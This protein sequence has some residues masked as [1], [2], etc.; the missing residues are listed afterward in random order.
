MQRS[1]PALDAQ[2]QH[3]EHTLGQ[4]PEMFGRAPSEEAYE[5]AEIFAR[6]GSRRILE[7]GAGQ[8]RDT[9]LLAEKGFAVV[10]LDYAE[11]GLGSIRQK[12]QALGL[13]RS[14][15]VLRHDVRDPLPFRDESFD[16]CY[17]HM[18]YCMVLK[19]AG[20]GVAFR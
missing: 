20:A 1:Q 10:A 15:N 17:S 4:K 18:L 8:G 5:A 11:S 3:W 6:E 12:F 2:K 7:L 14:V 16:V 9:V 13:C 19:A